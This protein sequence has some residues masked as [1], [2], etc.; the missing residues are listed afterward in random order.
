MELTIVADQYATGVTMR[1]P[2]CQRIRHDLSL[3]NCM[4]VSGECCADLY[5][6]LTVTMFPPE[7]LDMASGKRKRAENDDQ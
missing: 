4:S 5:L 7:I 2:R 6:L 1:F 3:E